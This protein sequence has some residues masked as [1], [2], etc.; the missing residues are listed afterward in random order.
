[1]YYPPLSEE[2]L[3]EGLAQVS[4]DGVV[5]AVQRGVAVHPEHVPVSVLSRDAVREGG[6]QQLVV[7]LALRQHQLA[8]HEDV[9]LGEGVD[10]FE[11]TRE[12]QCFK[13]SPRLTLPCALARILRVH[14]TLIVASGRFGKQDTFWAVLMQIL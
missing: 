8:D 6:P 2:N 7:E 13:K 12:L 3:E 5:V 4:R 9:E 10:N 1:M 14:A 11:T